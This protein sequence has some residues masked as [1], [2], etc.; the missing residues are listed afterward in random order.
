M[1]KLLLG[2]LAM[3]V[4]LLSAVSVNA[5]T[6]MT[7]DGVL[8]IE[9]PDPDTSS[10]I[11]VN[12]WFEISDP[13]YWFT[14][15]DGKSTITID[16]LSNGEALPQVQVADDNYAAAYQAFVST[17]N[18]VFVVKALA[19]DTATLQTL[20]EITG[21]IKVLKFDTKTTIKS[22][23]M[24][25]VSEFG[26]R[27]INA[28]YYS[29]TDDLNIR[30]G[31]ATDAPIIGTLGYGEEV[32]VKGAVTRNGQDYGWCQI[33]Y[34][35]TDAYVSASFLSATK[36]GG[37]AATDIGKAFRVWDANGNV[38][39]NLVRRSDGYY[40]SND[41][42]Q[43]RSNG[44]GS[45]T[46]AQVGDVLYDHDPTASGS[47][48]ATGETIT[49]YWLN[50]NAETLY[51]HGDGSYYNANGIRYVTCDGE[52]TGSDGT[53]LYPTPDALDA[54]V[55]STGDGESDTHMLSRKEDGLQVMVGWGGSGAFYDDN[56]TEYSWL[57]DGTMMDFFGNIYDVLW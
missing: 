40:Y 57:D 19:A 31:C 7:A 29:T 13:T 39:G 23:D 6:F 1:K 36:G 2:G 28:T 25:N 27:E 10:G 24:A 54:Y 49:V 47:G 15:S 4:M 26:L 35:G 30:T 18:E 46:G 45:Y 33:S 43:Y 9:T 16:H 11:P 14:I 17:K 8:S 32:L 21:S 52:Y 51:L 56:G 55:G 41:M 20:M 37:A 34:G 44:N 3:G 48:S 50:G 5:A 42:Q 38:Q 22:S 53:T 12:S